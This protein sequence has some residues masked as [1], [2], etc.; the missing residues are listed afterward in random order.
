MAHQ[1]FGQTLERV[2]RLNEYLKPELGT[3][4]DG[5]WLTAADLAPGAAPLETLIA[6]T[7]ARLRTTAPTI[8]ASAVLQSYQWPLISTAMACYLVDQRVPDL[9]VARV[10]THY[11]AEHE[12]DALALGSVRFVVL[13]SDP[14]ADCPDATVVADLD[15]LRTTVRTSIEAHLGTVIESLCARLGCK[16]RGLWLNVADSCA[17]TLVWLMQEHA[18]AT[19]PAQLEAEI[20]ALIRIPASP[21]YSRQIG[22]IELAYHERRQVFLDRATCCFWYKTEGGDYCSTCPKRTPNDRRERLLTYLAEEH[23]KQAEPVAQEAA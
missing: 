19:T 12:A 1:P 18:P 9:S 4:G 5:L 11:T 15:A 21:L 22:L 23:L 3:P 13:P 8:T 2:R 10:R 14:A 20:A 16:P 17:S 6:T 7:Q